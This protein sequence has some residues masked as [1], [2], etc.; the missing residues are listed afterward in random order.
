M[1]YADTRGLSF[2]APPECRTGY[3]SHKP[4]LQMWFFGLM[5][6]EYVAGLLA[7]KVQEGHCQEHRVQPD[8]NPCLK[9]R[10]MHLDMLKAFRADLASLVNEVDGRITDLSRLP[11]S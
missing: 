3:D 10:P 9:T 5:L 11:Q 1:E 7:Q 6:C 4:E 2:T 8:L